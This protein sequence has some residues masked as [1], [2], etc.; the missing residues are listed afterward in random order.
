M[1]REMS[2]SIEAA[3]WRAFASAARWNGQPAQAQIG[4]VSASATHSHPS[5]PKGGTMAISATGT[6]RTAATTS[7]RPRREPAPSVRSAP[8]AYAR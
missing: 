2:V 1:P 5:K 8:G 7:L 3:P 6:V 4:V